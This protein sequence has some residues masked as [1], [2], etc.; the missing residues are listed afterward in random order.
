VELDAVT[1]SVS[2]NF[3]VLMSLT[4][5]FSEYA[6]TFHFFELV[7]W[8]QVYINAS[9]EGRAEVMEMRDSVLKC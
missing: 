4:G 8:P 9:A 6:T 7:L 1:I 5:H 2:L 3:C